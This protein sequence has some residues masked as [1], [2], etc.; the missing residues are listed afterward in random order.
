MSTYVHF[1]WR[2]V[3]LLTSLQFA[4]FLLETL[5]F[6]HFPSLLNVILKSINSLPPQNVHNG[7]AEYGFLFEESHGI[8]S[9][10]IV[11]SNV[12][13]WSKIQVLKKSHCTQQCK[14]TSRDT[15]KKN[16]QETNFYSLEYLSYSW[17]FLT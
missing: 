5:G 7:Q 4:E 6:S 10:V 9:C 16:H 1:A 15:W 8:K 12:M 11:G 17:N 13:T 14:N 2:I 3:T